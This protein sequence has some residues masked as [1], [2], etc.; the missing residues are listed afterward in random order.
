MD[1]LLLQ[2]NFIYLIYINME[3]NRGK[4]KAKRGLA[5]IVRNKQEY[6]LIREFLGYKIAYLDWVPQ[7]KTTETSVIIWHDDPTTFSIGSVGSSDYQRKNDIRTI[8]FSKFFKN[9]P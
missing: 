8:E 7:M 9:K 3:T 4:I 5:V 6:D 1:H 2:L